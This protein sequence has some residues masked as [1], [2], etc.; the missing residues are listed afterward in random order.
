MQTGTFEKMRGE[1]EVDKTFIGGKARFMH[2]HR[3]AKAIKQGTWAD[4]KGG[5]HGVAR[6]LRRARVSNS[7]MRRDSSRST[8]SRFPIRKAR[9]QVPVP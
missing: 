7:R 1:V 3:R 2:K 9:H 6:V 5:G 8:F 4:G